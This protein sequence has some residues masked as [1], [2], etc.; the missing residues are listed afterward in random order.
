M[1]RDSKWC[2]LLLWTNSQS[3]LPFGA[4]TNTMWHLCH[5]TEVLHRIRN[6]H[7]RTRKRFLI[8]TNLQRQLLRPINAW[9]FY[10]E[11]SA[12]SNGN[13]GGKTGR[14][15][16]CRVCSFWKIRARESRQTK[17]VQNPNTV[18]TRLVFPTIDRNAEILS[19]GFNDRFS[20]Y[21][22]YWLF[23]NKFS[24]PDKFNIWKSR[25]EVFGVFTI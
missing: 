10:T 9:Y 1:R 22:M 12:G 16:D 6:F 5:A 15:S 13:F 21:W 14:T 19:T 25:V 8:T 4:K 7:H 20:G 3:W 17:F 11:I 2:L 24:L 23:M 18:K